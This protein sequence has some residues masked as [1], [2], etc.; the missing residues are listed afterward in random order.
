MIFSDFEC[1]IVD[2]RLVGLSISEID[3]LGFSWITIS[4]V[5][6]EKEKIHI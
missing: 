3:P 6:R 2:V 4:R 1:G 5:Y